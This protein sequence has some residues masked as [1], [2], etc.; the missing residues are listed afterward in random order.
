M[1]KI[2]LFLSIL[3]VILSG[4]SPNSEDTQIV[5]TTAPVYDLTMELCEGTGLQVTRLITE[6]VSCLHDYSLQVDQMRALE[7]A[8]TI[9]ISGAGMEE[10]LE[11]VLTG[12][13]S[14]IDSSEDVTLICGGHDHQDGEDNH[15]GHHHDHDPH[16]W[17][18]PAN[19]QRMAESICAGLIRQYPHLEETFHNNLT[20]LSEKLTALQAYAEENLSD[21]ACRE[22]ITFHDG[23]SYM[24]QSFGLHVLEAVEEES[25]SEASAAELIHLIHL[26]EENQ[27]PC[28]FTEANGSTAAAQIIASE[29][30]VPS[31][32]LDMAMGQ[33][34][35]FEAMYHNIDTLK[36][37]LG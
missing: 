29:T 15:D 18:S 13:A 22:I 11:D 25:G 19:A 23:F 8:Q 10:F 7:N 31:F 26:V 34:D 6:N 17:L 32:S 20:A 3:C 28:V 27:L 14:V 16:I 4:C 30:G 35:Y 2:L 1:K 21:I 5:A 33:R 36:E 24:A 12:K 9:I 37:A